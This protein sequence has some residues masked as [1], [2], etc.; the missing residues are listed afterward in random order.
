MRTPLLLAALLLA[1]CPSADP[2]TDDDDAVAND[3]DS[4]EAPVEELFKMVI[5]ADPH[6]AGPV[7]HEERTQAAVDWVNANATT[8][9]IELVVVLGDISWGS[10]LQAGFDLLDQLEPTWVPIIGDNVLHTSGDA[11]YAATYGPQLDEAATVLDDWEQAPWPVPDE[12]LGD[13]AWFQNIRFSH[14]GVLFV[15]VDWNIRHLSG[16]LAEFGD[17]NDV[18]GGTHDWLLDSL[19]GETERADESIVLLSH[20][21]MVLGTFSVAEKAAFAELLEPVRPKVFANFAGHLHI[22]AFDE[23][24]EAGYE[25]WVTDAIW[26]DVNMIRL[27]TISGNGARMEW[28]QEAI[29][30]E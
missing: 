21:P 4:T 28:A 9:G 7:E 26:D 16:N 8:L 30:L 27:V 3:D 25:T 11:A 2:V 18:P 12:R 22:D 10:R 1:G 29:E 17:F 24:F 5:I 23:D 6:V 20:V 14:K 15:G 19:D 13:D